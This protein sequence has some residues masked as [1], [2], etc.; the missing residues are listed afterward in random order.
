M[1]LVDHMITYNITGRS[2]DHLQ[3]INNGQCVSYDNNTEICICPTGYHGKHCEHG[4][5]IIT[6]ISLVTIV[7]IYSLVLSKL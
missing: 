1:L 2:C 7:T 3:C 5:C 4:E 6:T